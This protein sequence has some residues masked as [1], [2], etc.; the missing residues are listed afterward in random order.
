MIL[1]TGATGF[2]G[3]HLVEQLIKE[4][5]KKLG[6]K[7]KIRCLVLKE[8]PILK[9]VNKKR[10]N[11]LKKLKVEI[12]YGDLLKPETLDN[13]LKNVDKVFHLA[14]ISKP[15]NIP[16]QKYYDINVTGVKNLLQAAEK[17]KVKKI[18][19]ISTMSVFGYS[20]D[21]KP[22][23]ENSPKLP[24]SDYG[25]SK[26]QGEQLVLNFCKKNKI[27][28][29]IIRPPMVFGERDFQFLKLF[30]GINTGF[31]PLL[32][33]G[34]A[35]FEFC[36]VKNLVYGILL[37]DKKAKNLENYNITGGK[38]YTIK[39]VF[40]KIAELE[41]KKLIYFPAWLF[42][43]T[44]YVLEIIYPIFG[45]QPPFNSGTSD[46]MTKDNIINISKIK[47]LGYKQKIPLE[48]SLKNTIKY[49]KKN[50]LL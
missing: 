31:F 48:K 49:Y 14:A 33:N 10:I 3:S 8:D 16:T 43:L 37:I 46:W 20:R 9:Q 35:K 1:V 38:K 34:K 23:T 12:V 11:L 28:L 47:K 40:E 4:N 44:G 42:K 19:H 2:I 36:Y 41:G 17:N 26:K 24:V 39:E 6:K 13:A 50:N 21:K 45:K 29:N 15:M 7:E 22:L 27:K 30:K 32:K 18:I 25:K 5:K